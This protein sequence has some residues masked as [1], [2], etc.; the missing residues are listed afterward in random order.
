[1]EQSKV[2][3]ILEQ[4]K[5]ENILEQ[6]KMTKILGRSGKIGASETSAKKRKKTLTR[7]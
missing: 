1:M 2:E 5:V 7:L 3:N 4:S 6:R